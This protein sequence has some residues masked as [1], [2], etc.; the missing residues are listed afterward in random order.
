M[1]ENSKQ[2]L[3]VVLGLE[4][5]K[6]PSIT[7]NQRQYGLYH[8][9]DAMMS[10]QY[11]GSFSQNG[12]MFSDRIINENLREIII[13]LGHDYFTRLTELLKRAG[14]IELGNATFNK[15]GY[16]SPDY[17]RRARNLTEKADIIIFYQPWVFP[18]VKDLIIEGQQ[19]V[20]YDSAAVEGYH[21]T[22]LLDDNQYGTLVAQNVVQLECELCDC[23]DL[24]LTRNQKDRLALTKLY[25][26]NLDKIKLI[27][28]GVF[29]Q[30]IKPCNSKEQGKLKKELGFNKKYSAIYFADES[31]AN[32]E[33]VNFLCREAS[34]QFD[35]VD[36]III[37]EVGKTNDPTANSCSEAG[38]VRITDSLDD[39]TKLRY[40]Q[41]CDIAL[42]L[43]V[44][45]PKINTRMLEFMAAGLPTLF[46]VDSLPEN[47]KLGDV[48]IPAC[49]KSEFGQ[50]LRDLLTNKLTRQNIAKQV[51]SAAEE[52]YS[53]ERLSPSLGR[54]IRRW[55][56]KKKTG[57]PFFSIIIPTFERHSQL[58][59]L[60]ETLSIQTFRDFEVVVVDQSTKSWDGSKKD[61]GFE[62]CYL[63]TDIIGA[64]KARNVAGFYALGKI[65]AFTDDDCEPYSNWL[66]NGG[67]YFRD[68]TV[69][70]IEGL[71][72][73][74]KMNN[75]NYRAVSNLD[76]NGIGFM[77]ANL[78]VR[79]DIFNTIDGFD[80]IF[81]NPHFREDTDFGW[82]ALQHGKIPFAKDTIV[83]HP[84]HSRHIERESE[85]SR[86]LYFEK[87]PLLMS[88]HPEKYFE[89]FNIEQH[90]KNTPGFWDNFFIGATKYRIEVPDL[91]NKYYQEWMAAKRHGIEEM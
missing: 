86:A 22:A 23:A 37:G 75:C 88:R 2:M 35:D 24:I 9:L 73:S 70:G 5:L 67:K 11:I 51:R 13:P 45:S 81:D 42:N 8:G 40:L 19:L 59:R 21:Y 57:R 65:F 30:K 20:I 71:I 89:L 3:I 7:E 14:G 16:L 76:F 79:A 74:D 53:W 83:F 62:L 80:E 78:M 52:K 27:P 6:L 28:D 77:T 66:E 25:K 36:F 91:Y 15:L 49:G 38:N 58:S 64:V 17:L 33:A 69:V 18:L 90:W 55:Y 61:W 44:C 84:P 39:N 63:K 29:T 82:R 56:L 87:D 60:F 85:T 43:S 34:L 12:E 4:P 50:Q 68:Q 32:L 41:A 1:N 10:T 31:P 46:M 47:S 26:V 72:I 54:L 48:E